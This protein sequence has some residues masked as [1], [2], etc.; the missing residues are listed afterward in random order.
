MAHSPTWS[1]LVI[2]GRVLPPPLSLQ[3]GQRY[4]PLATWLQNVVKWW[5]LTIV[6]HL[7]VF[8]SYTQLL[9]AHPVHSSCTYC[10]NKVTGRR[11]WLLQRVESQVYRSVLETSVLHQQASIRAKMVDATSRTRQ[12][13][14]MIEACDSSS[15]VDNYI[16]EMALNNMISRSLS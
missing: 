8:I 16:I 14:R 3:S 13:T 10:A 1:S 9:P 4:F 6:V 7:R 15:H 11:H 12:C 2:V 5:N